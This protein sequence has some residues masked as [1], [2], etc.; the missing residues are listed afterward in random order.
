MNIG[1]SRRTAREV[2]RLEGES[3]GAELLRS[4]ATWTVQYLCQWNDHF[5]S[6]EGIFKWPE[7]DSKARPGMLSATQA[8]HSELSFVHFVDDGEARTRVRLDQICE[9]RTIVRTSSLNPYQELSRFGPLFT[10]HPPGST[11]VVETEAILLWR[12]LSESR[13]T[14]PLD[15]MS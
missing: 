10:N 13:T 15:L 12:K 1:S 2:A 7:I 11:G 8:S 14:I 5:L 3:G 9:N 4:V 6:L